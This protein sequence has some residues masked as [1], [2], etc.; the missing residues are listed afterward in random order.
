MKLFRLGCYLTLVI[1]SFGFP[2]KAVRAQAQESWRLAKDKDQIQVYTRN[3][4]GSRSTELKVECTMAGTQSQLVA[5]LSDIANYK[6]VIYKTKSARLIRRVSE[7]ELLYYVVT[8]VPWPVSDRDMSV[9][10]TFAQD[11]ASKVLEVK[12]VGVPNL[13]A[14]QPNTVRIAD[15]L[16]IWNVRPINKQRMQVT[17]TCR[18][19]PG[20]DIP[21]WL[22]NVAAASSA[23]QSF[24]LIRNSL[25]LPRYQGKTFAFLSN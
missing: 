8:S 12:G 1:G 24:V 21:A 10:L 23:Y 22:D 4:P 3:I 20:G 14:A 5:L 7:T 18:L 16:A 17:Y 11:P 13:V 2:L 19:D 25:S 15:W 9:Q 6:N